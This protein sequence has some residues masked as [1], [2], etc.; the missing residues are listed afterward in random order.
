MGKTEP[1]TNVGEVKQIEHTITVV[2]T[3]FTE[4]LPQPI[5]D[6]LKTM[7]D[8]LLR[9]VREHYGIETVTCR[10][11]NCEVPAVTAHLHQGDWICDEECWDE[12]LRS[13]E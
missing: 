10:Y 3:I 12:R 9:E 4:G 11:C 1:N 13:S 6:E 7:L 8:D 5:P 2:F